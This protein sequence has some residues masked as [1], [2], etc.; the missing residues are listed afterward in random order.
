MLSVFADGINEK[1]Y[2]ILGDTIL[3][4]E[5]GVPLLIEDYLEDVRQ[6]CACI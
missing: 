1:A 6:I 3:E 4:I 2:E 5:D